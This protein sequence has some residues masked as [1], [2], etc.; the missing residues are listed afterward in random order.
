MCDD[1]ARGGE[2][3]APP[4]HAPSPFKFVKHTL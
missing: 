3:P 4:H 2:P 1:N